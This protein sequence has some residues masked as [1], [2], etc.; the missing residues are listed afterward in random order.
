[1]A[2]CVRVGLR[3][4]LLRHHESRRHV[5]DPARAGGDGRASD[6]LARGAGLVVHKGRQ[7]DESESGQEHARFRDE[8][9]TQLTLRASEGMTA[10]LGTAT[11]FLQAL[12]YPLACAQG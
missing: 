12:R 4:S 5:H 7:D 11:E 6:G 2:T 3:S 8:R 9:K 10:S 1:M